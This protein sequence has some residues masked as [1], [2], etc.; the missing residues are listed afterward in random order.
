MLMRENPYTLITDGS[1]DTGREKMNPLTVRVFDVNKVG[2]RF[3]D[4]C[5]TSGTRCGTAELIF[6][7]IDGQL[8]ENCIPWC[9]C[10]GL[11]VDN[12]A[13]NIGQ[14]NSIASRILQ[15]NSSVYVH[16]CPCHILHNTAKQAG[17]SFAEVADFDIEDIVVDVG[18]WFKGSTNRK[19]FLAEY[20][21]ILQHVSV[22]WLSLETCVTRILRLYEPL[23]S[24]F[25]STEE[26]QPRLKRLQGAF[27]DPMTEVYLLFYQATIPV[28]TSLN[29]LL[30]RE[31]PSI[32]LLQDEMIKFIRKL[33][34]KFI[35]PTV[36]QSHHKP[37]DIPYVDKENHLPGNKLSVGFTT[38]ARLNHLL[39]AG[40]ITAHQV[41]KFQTAALKFLMRAVEYA[42]QKLPLREPLLN[43]ARFV[44]VR[45]RAECGVEDA[46][47]FVERYV[48]LLPYHSPQ[49]HD[50]LGEEFLDY[51]TMPLP[52]LE[53]DPDIEGFWANMASLKH[54]VTGVGRFERLSTMAKL[55]L[56]LP[57]SNADAERVF[58]LVG[59]NK[60]KT[61][62]QP[63]PGG[64][65]V[66]SNGNQ[67][68]RL[69]AMLQV[70][71]IQIND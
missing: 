13:V 51:Q 8:Q 43:H 40:D 25:K 35:L 16:G 67:G 61:K 29:L 44:D 1:N 28:F 11:S 62:K 34:S 7:K 53:A 58:S 26:N 17:F 23:A 59:L 46:L 27:S 60:T 14:R 5:T 18:F 68:G 57:H 32:F 37:E 31:N 52:R 47:Y 71:A 21:E 41:D 66:I 9:N 50:A 63:C 22:R 49:E 19:G 24:Y 36:L 6:E 55:V 10:V 48:H 4:M 3:L 45:Q 20:V 54:K 2:H 30:Q 64:N 39:D 33:C 42:L 15:K 69:G 12:A 38:R 56:V 65:T 70:G